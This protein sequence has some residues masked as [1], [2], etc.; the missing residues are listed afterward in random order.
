MALALL[1]GAWL[2]FLVVSGGRDFSFFGLTLTA[3]NPLRP[4]LGLSFAVAVL[5]LSTRAGAPTRVW[6]LEAAR[7]DPR[8]VAAAMAL[9]ALGIGLRYGTNVAGGSDS[10]SYVSEAHAWMDGSLVTTIPWA[11]RV[12]WPAALETF[13]PLGHV[14]TFDRRGVAAVVPPGLPLL[15]AGA[16]RVAGQCAMFWVVPISGAVI[17]WS[18]Y[19]LGRR[20][21]GAATGLGAAALVLSS[22]VFLLYVVQPMSDVPVTA[23]WALAFLLLSRPSAIASAGAGVATAVA[24]LI[25]PNLAPLAMLPPA[26][27]AIKA[28][29]AWRVA[30]SERALRVRQIAAFVAGLAPA[31]IVL[32]LVNNSLFGSPL[33][34]G[35]GELGMLFSTHNIVPNARNYF[36]WFVQIATALPLA[37]LVALFLPRVTK[38]PA[39]TD[40][41]FVITLGVFIVLLVA[42]Y[43]LYGVFDAW[44][45]L[46]FLL[47]A[48]PFLMIAFVHL[49]SR[50]TSWSALTSVAGA[51]VVLLL[52]VR[53]VRISTAEHAFDLWHGEHRYVTIAGL[54]RD[55]TPGESVVLAGQHS[56][57]LRY[58]G[59]R[60]TMNYLWM[61]RAWLDRTVAWLAEHGQRVY[62]LLDEEEL[63]HFKQYF[64]G[65]RRLDRL[66][67]APVLAYRASS[68]A[69]LFDLAADRTEP[70][71]LVRDAPFTGDRCPPRASPPAL[72]LK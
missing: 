3:H 28:L 11:D 64:A 13:M 46:R 27:L 44:W 60:M 5:M 26:W 49:L 35:Y 65:A 42:Q 57:S 32:A 50:L 19:S 8:L 61:D 66:D 53:G 34:S 33:K 40:S 29:R 45:Y 20:L 68:T 47:P 10:F 6:R 72:V 69:R 55:L 48:W 25:R 51:I 39:G 15:M 52:V 9:G 41:A 67:A 30:P 43:C 59:G 23:A 22:P 58:Y 21:S 36:G 70:T 31:G 7:V 4:L 71:R 63:A 14:P 38:W 17:I 24:V 12:P 16:A 1:A 2:L 37:G 56:G 18:T 62:A 54:V